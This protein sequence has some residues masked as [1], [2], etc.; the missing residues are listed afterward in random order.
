MKKPTKRHLTILI[1]YL[2]LFSLINTIITS[3]KPLFFTSQSIS[4]NLNSS[5][6]RK[7]IVLP[8]TI[9]GNT[10]WHELSAQQD[11]CTGSGSEQDPFIISNIHINANNKSNAL[12]VKNSD[13]FFII[14]NC[15][16]ENSGPE[17]G[18][19]G[20]SLQNVSNAKV[21]NTNCSSNNWF[22]IHVK[23]CLNSEIIDNIINQNQVG[24]SIDNSSSC[25]IEENTYD[26]NMYTAINLH[27]VSNI[28]V[29]SN[30]ISNNSYGVSLSYS[31]RNL[32]EYNMLKNNAVGIYLHL[33][34][35]DNV[36]RHNVLINTGGYYDCI[37]E[38]MDSNNNEYVNNTCLENEQDLNANNEKEDPTIP[39]GSF[40]I[41]I[42]ICTITIIFA[43]VKRN[44]S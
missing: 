36:I 5:N 28:S 30:S 22:G 23:N 7:L 39:F 19:S 32:I 42:T 40:F 2:I 12:S 3:H 1:P 6:P 35:N 41:L 8:F 15:R 9:D 17:F 10:D 31:V 11:W 13:L 16:F 20:I 4:N 18:N 24:I 33:K 43:Y 34:S 37:S 27:Q 29:L 38:E 14:R 26:D 21:T 44:T 25:R